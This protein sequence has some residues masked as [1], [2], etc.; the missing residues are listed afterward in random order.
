MKLLEC[1]GLRWLR[2]TRFAHKSTALSPAQCLVE[3]PK[4]CYVPLLLVYDVVPG[5]SLDAPC[6]HYEFESECPRDACTYIVV[7]L[8]LLLT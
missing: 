6:H 5:Q 7:E 3:P 1:N 4:T 2:K 8:S